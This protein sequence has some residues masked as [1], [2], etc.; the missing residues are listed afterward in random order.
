MSH[1]HPPPPLDERFWLELAWLTAETGLPTH[2]QRLQRLAD[3]LACA[4]PHNPVQMAFLRD[5]ANGLVQPG[6]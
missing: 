1:P 3:R 2:E 4:D 5:M 6:A